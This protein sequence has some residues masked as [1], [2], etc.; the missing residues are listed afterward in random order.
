LIAVAGDRVFDAGDSGT[1]SAIDANGCGAI[2][3]GPVWQGSVGFATAGIA[4][5]ADRVYVT[6]GTT[7]SV[8]DANGCGAATCMP[9]WTSTAVGTLTAPTMVNDVVL[10]GSTNGDLL[11]WN[12]DG[13]GAPTCSPVWSEAQ[14][15]PVGP[16]SPLPNGMVF[17]VGGSVRKLSLT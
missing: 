12:V 4:A 13:C 16:V 7:L 14:G 17:P 1:V 6:A 3:C 9:L 10:A 11:A 5:T 15:A 2:T 8:F